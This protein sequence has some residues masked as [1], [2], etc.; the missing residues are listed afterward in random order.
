MILAYL[1]FLK[2]YSKLIGA[3]SLQKFYLVW[4]GFLKVEFFRF[5][6]KI[7]EGKKPFELE[8]QYI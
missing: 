5:R 6:E 2:M 1:F 4:R 8:I 7:V 3:F